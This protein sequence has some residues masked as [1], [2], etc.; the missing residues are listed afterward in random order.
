MYM[1]TRVA[2]SHFAG[3]LRPAQGNINYTPTFLKF[4]KLQTVP[5]Y[6]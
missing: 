6:G 3:H 4:K 1:Y 2:L 5:D